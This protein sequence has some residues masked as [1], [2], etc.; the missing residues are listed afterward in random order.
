MNEILGRDILTKR[1][2]SQISMLKFGV[3]A[4]RDYSW[5]ND[6]WHALVLTFGIILLMAS[7]WSNILHENPGLP[8]QVLCT[9]TVV[10]VFLTTISTNVDDIP[11]TNNQMVYNSMCKDVY[12]LVVINYQM[13]DVLYIK[14]KQ[15]DFLWEKKCISSEMFFGQD[16]VVRHILI[17][18][19]RGV[20]HASEK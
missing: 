7:P 20:H 5:L 4:W 6:D 17:C 11:V 13:V 16:C 10:Q 9:I 19:A 1:K 8:L 14:R 12:S 15:D 3:L 18:S 2:H